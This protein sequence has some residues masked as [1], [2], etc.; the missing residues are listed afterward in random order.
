MTNKVGTV[1]IDLEA[2]VAQLETD[3]GRA[4]RIFDREI[5]KMRRQTV[6]QLRQINRAAE[7]FARQFRTALAGALGAVSVRELAR[8]SSEVINLADQ[9]TKLSRSLGL[10]TSQISELQ[11][12]ARLSGG[13][14]ED[15][16]KAVAKLAKSSSD[17]AQGL[18]TYKRAFDALDIT[19]VDAEGNLKSIDQLLPEIADKFAAAEDGTAKTAVAMDIFGR[20]GAKLVPLLNQG[21]AGLA[22][23]ADQARRTGL[24]I[25]TDTGRAAEEFND[26]MTRL[27]DN[28]RGIALDVN[29]ELLPGMV[30]LTDSIV[31][32]I[33]AARADGSLKEFVGTITDLIKLVDDLAVF[34]TTKLVAGAFLKLIAAGG[35][36][37]TILLTLTGS[38]KGLNTVVASNP[39]GLLT[40]GLALAATGM[41]NFRDETDKSIVSV[42]RLESGMLDL[43]NRFDDLTLAQQKA[44]AVEF[45]RKIRSIKDA[46][47]ALAFEIQEVVNRLGGIE[48]GTLSDSFIRALGFKDSA[49][50]TKELTEQLTLLE[51]EISGNQARIDGYN[52]TLEKM[53]AVIGGTVERLKATKAPLRTYTTEL[54]KADNTAERATAALQQ[55]M[56]QVKD[57]AA[58]LRGPTAV[59][60]RQ[61]ER[62][63]EEITQV[64]QELTDT[65]QLSEDALKALTAARLQAV[66]ALDQE[67]DAIA[68]REQ[69]NIVALYQAETAAIIANTGN[70]FDLAN[71]VDFNRQ[72]QE[73]LNQAK[74]EGTALS[75]DQAKAL[76][77]E[78]Q[79]A[80][81]AAAALANLQQI[82][83]QAFDSLSNSLGDFI[84]GG[85]KDFEGFAKSIASTLGNAIAQIGQSFGPL[86]GF[87][88]NIAGSLIS[89]IPNLFKSS[90]RLQVGGA[91]AG[92]IKATD[93]SDSIFDTALGQ[94][95]LDTR[96]LGD[97]LAAIQQS[98]IDF[99]NT[100]AGILSDGQLDAVTA[101]LEN[102]RF[103]AKGK[104]LDISQL[105]EARFDAIID[106]LGTEIATLVERIGG[107]LEERQARLAGVLGIDDLI[108]SGNALVAGSLTDVVNLLDDLTDSGETLQQTY[109][110]LTEQTNNYVDTLASAG[111]NATRTGEDLIRFVDALADASGGLQNLNDRLATAITTFLD[112]EQLLT[113]QLANAQANA[114]NLL[115]GLGIDPGIG[116]AGFGQVLTDALGSNIGP[117]ALADLLEA[118]EAL[119]QVIELESQLT[120]IREQAAQTAADAAAA[121][122]NFLNTIR[123]QINDL[124]GA[125]SPFRDELA[126]INQQFAEAAARVDELGLGEDALALA[127]QRQQLQIQALIAQITASIT[128]L[129]GQLFGVGGSIDSAVTAGTSSINTALNNTFSQWQSALNAISNSIDNILL[130]NL[131]TLTPTQQLAEA[132]AQFDALIAAANGGDAGAAA[133][134]PQALQQLLQI[135]QF[136]TGGVGDFEQIFANAIA[137]AESVQAP[138]GL[139]AQP[140]NA[141]QVQNIGQAAN[142]IVGNGLQQI[143]LAAQLVEQL[144]ILAELTENSGIELANQLQIPLDQL[145]S[146]LGV[147]LVAPTLENVR[148]LGIL[149]E[150]LGV[151]LNAL[152]SEIG[153]QIGQLAD[154]ESLLNDALENAILG[155]PPELTEP[156]LAALAILEETGNIA[157]LLEAVGAL[158]G[159]QAN[160]LAPFIDQI[161]I[162]DAAQQ[163]ISL[164]ESIESWTQISA[165]ALESLTAATGIPGFASGT[166]EITRSG[167]A[168]VHA[169]EMIP[170]ADVSE[171]MRQAINVPSRSAGP[172]IPVSSAGFGGAS[173]VEQLL[174]QVVSE[175]SDLR[176]EYEKQNMLLQSQQG[177]SCA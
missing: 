46:N 164:L 11:F 84:A 12:A 161:D 134:I 39:V 145:V 105:F 52:E 6:A 120:A 37:N 103:E 159:E 59:A 112:P 131:S 22:D 101:A 129:A 97:Q 166:M 173:N 158:P 43:I 165:N 175:V 154:S 155:L 90:P 108:A 16:S 66:K 64:Q 88:G 21:A 82:G 74:Q 93:S 167:L 60:F 171:R 162:T 85:L 96:R 99:D 8:M 40:T 115:S 124:K 63:L 29:S 45:E 132:Q 83:L 27:Q 33:Q 139:Q 44:A 110:R 94:I 51:G 58:E 89:A 121:E 176:T 48:F 34:I 107:S 102:F 17:A 146:I 142:Q 140:P 30:R 86:G 91:N 70:I 152:T 2:R 156:L 109:Q 4:A 23:L 53:R 3:V 42:D 177:R 25:G 98:L 170:P 114:T 13:T 36:L 65:N 135:A 73:L 136:V 56:E 168:V 62:A 61:F 151:G 9:T 31:A 80:E 130:G 138:T 172:A 144:G 72:V 117:E 104:D 7:S 50:A 69:N 118:A 18:T 160:A 10:T 174:G 149:S 35:S 133:Q 113:S 15:L 32:F 38:V 106:A 71:A 127:R 116:A 76:V 87:L 5:N 128:D 100:L 157:P 148:T 41:F 68:E 95:Q 79:A 28:I 119:G 19:V 54:E 126:Q 150:T 78:R 55:L 92:G 163:Q 137:A 147:D 169:G 125:I 143:E 77:N 67:I 57:Q 141:Q 49:E 24:V 47:E 1:S 75:G 153:V 123:E 111:V 81:D 26:N 20:S 14:A 122:Q